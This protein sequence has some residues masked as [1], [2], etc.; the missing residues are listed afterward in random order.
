MASPS[1]RHQRTSQREHENIVTRESP[2]A[3][4]MLTRGVVQL[5]H[6]WAVAISTSVGSLPDNRYRHKPADLERAQMT[7]TRSAITVT[8]LKAT[9][10][11]IDGPSRSYRRASQPTTTPNMTS[12]GSW[13][14]W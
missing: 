2:R 3:I 5:E 11:K 9:W 1:S 14:A 7:L 13:I 4:V 10:A 8:P 6:R 12:A